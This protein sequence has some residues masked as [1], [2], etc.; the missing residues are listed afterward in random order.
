MT[1]EFSNSARLTARDVET[2]PLTLSGSGSLTSFFASL[3]ATDGNPVIVSGG[4]SLVVQGGGAAG[5]LRLTGGALS[6]LGAFGPPVSASAGTLAVTG[7]LSLDAASSMTL[8]IGLIGCRGSEATSTTYR[9]SP[10]RDRLTSAAL[11]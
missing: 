10:R 6:L 7:G 3:N 8:Q 4:A 5:P 2:G 9:R 1:V 11:T